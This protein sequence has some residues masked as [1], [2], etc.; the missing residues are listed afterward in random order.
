MLGWVAIR[1]WTATWTSH[2]LMASGYWVG[3]GIMGFWAM[4]Q[5]VRI[6]MRVLMRCECS[7]NGAEG[8]LLLMCFS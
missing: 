5:G 3:A 6:C 8:I 1:V 7:E 4:A 2:R